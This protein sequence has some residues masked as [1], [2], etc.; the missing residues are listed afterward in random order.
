MKSGPERTGLKHR[1]RFREWLALL[2]WDLIY[3]LG[4]VVLVVL[5]TL[6][7]SLIGLLSR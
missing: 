6:L 4:T 5:L 3:A 2:P 1:T 7:V